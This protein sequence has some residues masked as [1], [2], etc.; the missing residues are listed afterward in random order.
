MTDEIPVKVS[1]LLRRIRQW[2]AELQAV[3]GE[4][5][6]ERL[7]EAAPDGWSVRDQIAHITAWERSA[8]AL[9]SGVPRHEAMG[10]TR[11]EWTGD[12]DAANERLRRL[13]QERSSE[14]VR[15][16]FK[17]VHE[18]LVAAIE[19]LAD[20]DLSR[21]YSSFLPNEPDAADAPVVGWINGNTSEHYEEHLA[22]LRAMRS[23]EGNRA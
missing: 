3:L 18:A 12:V 23:A 11:E 14:T 6:A 17:E 19:R 5:T 20:E 8:L 1:D 2:R 7:A 9:V 21:P 4:L 15:R 16:E 13:S 10:L 22:T